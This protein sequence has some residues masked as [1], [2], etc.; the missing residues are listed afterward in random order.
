MLAAR[1]PLSDIGAAPT[2]VVAFAVADEPD[3]QRQVAT[4][5]VPADGH[6]AL[7]GMVGSG[8]T[9]AVL[10]VVEAIARMWTAAECHVY[11]I[12]YGSNGLAP[13]QALPHVGAVISA[14]EREAQ[15][16]LIRFLRAEV[17]RRRDT[18]ETV[19]RIVTCVDGVGA[20]LAEHESL[21]GA[22]V[23]EAFRRVFSEG[24]AVGI[25][26]IVTADRVGALPLR[27]TSLVSQKLLF[28]LADAS[29]YSMLGLRS[30]QLPR[31]VPG[32]AV[33]SDGNR[34]VQI[35]LP[36]D[37][38]A[39]A[40]PRRAPPIG[41][42]PTRVSVA[43]LPDARLDSPCHL[44]L[45]IAEDDL[46]VAW[47]RVHD[48]EHVLVTGPPRSGKT[49][50]LAL[51]AQRIRSADADAVL[52]GICEPRSV[53]H[54]VDA[55]DATGSLTELEHIVRAAATDTRRWFVIVDDA[56]TVEDVGGVITTALRSGRAHLHV[57]A[58]GRADD[59]RAAYGHWLRI[60]RQSRAGLLLQPD[61]AV[62]GD[63]LGVRLPRRLAVPLVPGR[64]FAVESG[65]A[66]LMQMALHQTA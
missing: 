48:G 16:R 10:S 45:G 49:N 32:R 27:L 13:L 5:W 60:V 43:A 4:G 44:P 57:I 63:L 56:P 17:D 3:Q 11:A 42:L 8:T 20:F 38:G 24:P 6:L 9:T 25:T 19:P 66:T 28:R 12:D 34:V 39:L 54:G 58:A 47:L 33:H 37:L 23:S 29:D 53:L 35:G 61:L 40:G 22:E 15:G 52:V 51:V 7:F 31:F 21:D 30:G 62:D 41:T 55:F 2:G 46:D 14:N 36:G 65:D 50:A 64:G 1:I 26:F 59:V 18:G